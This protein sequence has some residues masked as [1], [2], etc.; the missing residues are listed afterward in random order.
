MIKQ[1]SLV[2][3][4]VFHHQDEKP[5][6]RVGIAIHEIFNNPYLKGCWRVAWVPTKEHP[7]SNNKD[8]LYFDHV[9]KQN[10]ILLSS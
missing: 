8:S 2:K 1:G 7:V 6:T 3:N 4:K 9:K 5:V 10:L